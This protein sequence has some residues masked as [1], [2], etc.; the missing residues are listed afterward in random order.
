M[1]NKKFLKWLGVSALLLAYQA[2]N[3]TENGYV[4]TSNVWNKLTIPVCWINPDANNATERQWVQSAVERTWVRNS[5]VA[6]T[7][8]GTSCPAN[9]QSNT[10]RILIADVGPHVKTLGQP[11]ITQAEGMVLNFTFSAWSPSCASSPTMRREC[12]ESI[13]VHEFGHVLGFAHEQNRP[14]R[15]ST[16]TEPAQGSSGN[17]TIGAWDINSVMNYC[18]PSYNGFGALSPIDIQTVQTYYKTPLTDSNFTFDANF[19]LN[20]YPDLRNAFGYNYQA[21]L[22]H[23]NLSGIKEGRRASREFDV[24]FYLSQYPDLKAAFGT[25]Y[26]AALNHWITA[27]I[28]EGRQGSRE[29]NSTYYLNNYSDLYA[30]FGQNYRAGLNHWKANGLNEGRKAASQ[31]SVQSY[32]ARYADLRTAYQYTNSFNTFANDYTLGFQHWVTNGLNE[33]RVGN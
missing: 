9:N 6:F 22:N 23:W 11:V 16:C 15:P 21:A 30:A 7:G 19:Y 1:I 14:D 3:A 4:L 18:N 26:T 17:V 8:W 29:V 27:G 24:L 32:F 31:F 20:R 28:A 2:S 5:Q 10:V 25:N 12:I 33:G 13:G